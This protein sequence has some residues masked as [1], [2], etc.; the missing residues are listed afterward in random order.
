M[1]ATRQKPRPGR[2]VRTVS[3]ASGVAMAIQPT[4]T[5]AIRA[6]VRATTQR[7][8][9]EDQVNGIGTGPQRA[10]RQVH[11]RGEQE[12]R[13][14]GGR[15]PYD[16]GRAGQTLKQP[17]RRRA[18]YGPDQLDYRRHLRVPG[19]RCKCLRA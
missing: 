9:A 10:E 18:R 13:D 12:C 17:L 6:T 19:L 5:A 1:V 7:V 4:M 8:R 2:S 11:R 16:R 15:H 3:Q 14:D